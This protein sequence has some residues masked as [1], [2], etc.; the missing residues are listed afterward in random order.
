[1]KKLVIIKCKAINIMCNYK[2]NSQCMYTDYCNK[3]EG[4]YK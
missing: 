1:M 2:T 4:V 3:K